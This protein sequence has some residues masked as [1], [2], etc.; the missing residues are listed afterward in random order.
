MDG[1]HDLKRRIKSTKNTRQMT[2]AMEAVSATKMRH[3]VERAISSRAYS[4]TIWNIVREL[5]SHD[6]SQQHPLLSVR[7]PRRSVGI[8]I[9]SDRGLC[10]GFN[11]SVIRAFTQAITERESQGTEVEII[12]VGK[13]G[14]IQL[15]RLNKTLTEAYEKWNDQPDIV[16]VRGL[17]AKLIQRYTKKEIDEVFIGY[18]DFRSA[19]RQVARVRRMFPI[20]LDPIEFQTDRNAAT[21]YANGESFQ[22]FLFEPSRETV[23]ELLLPRLLE[24]ELFQL[25]LESSASEHSSRMMTMRN[26]TNNAQ[27]MINEL[28]LTYNQVRQAAITQEIAEIAAGR[29]ALE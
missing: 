20:G 2:R 8:I 12:A 23:L 5:R 27:D 24:V 21:A 17:I 16:G 1:L 22:E 7:Q 14:T 13:K 18:T 6:S 15:L 10:G 4:H 28:T 19:L 25:L 9:T 11:T 3:A 29:A 26:A